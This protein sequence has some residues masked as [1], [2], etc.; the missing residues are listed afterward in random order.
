MASYWRLLAGFL[1]IN[2]WHVWSQGM[3]LDSMQSASGTETSSRNGS[4]DRNGPQHRHRGYFQKANE[5]KTSVHSQLL[6]TE[7]KEV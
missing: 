6:Y 7:C 5:G 1:P 3:V 4:L 2:D